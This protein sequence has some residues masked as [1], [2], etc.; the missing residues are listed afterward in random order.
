MQRFRGSVDYMS[1]SENSL[2]TATHSERMPQKPV[3]FSSTGASFRIKQHDFKRD[4]S[5]PTQVP[6]WEALCFRIQRAATELDAVTTGRPP[7]WGKRVR[8]AAKRRVLLVLDDLGV[9][10]TD[11]APTW[12]RENLAAMDSTST[13]CLLSGGGAILS[14]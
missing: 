7:S 8:L 12:R 3:S 9:P 2:I 4:S 11:P 6:R 10:S 5:S 14:R 1:C 13:E